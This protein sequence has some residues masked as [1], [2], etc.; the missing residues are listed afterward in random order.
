MVVENYLSHSDWRIKEN[1][2]VHFS[3]GGLVLYNSGA[4]TA[5]HWLEKVYPA[6]VAHAHRNGD[7]HI[8]DLSML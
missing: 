3:L 2:N 1:A 4:L 8:H 6:E 5:E 7:L